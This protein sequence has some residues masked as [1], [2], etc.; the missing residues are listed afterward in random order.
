M[1]MT[2]PSAPS[3]STT[4]L[5]IEEPSADD[6]KPRKAPLR[7]D[8]PEPPAAVRTDL[9]EHISF[10]RRSRLQVFAQAA[11]EVTRRGGRQASQGLRAGGVALARVPHVA[12]TGIQAGAG[13][14]GGGVRV[15]AVGMH[16]GVR[17]TGRSIV[18][19]SGPRVRA[20]H[21]RGALALTLV[22]VIVLGIVGLAFSA[23]SEYAAF[24]GLADGAL[25]AFRRLPTDLGLGGS[26]LPHQ[27]IT[28]AQQQRA[29]ADLDLAIQ[30][31]TAIRAR[32]GHPDRFVAFASQ[33]ESIAGLLQGA[34]TLS[35]MALD[36]AQ[37]AENLL[38]GGL[39]L[40]NALISSPLIGNSAQGAGMTLGQFQVLQ[41][42]WDQSM[43][44]LDDLVS[45][46]QTT[47]RASLLALLSAKQRAEIAPLLDQLPQF[48]MTTVPLISQFLPVAPAVLGIGQPANYLVVTMDTSEL[49]PAGGFQG[50]YSVFSLDGARPSGLSLRDIYLLDDAKPQDCGVNA[51]LVVPDLYSTW[52][53]YCPWGV[54]DANLSPDFP[55]SAQYSLDLLKTLK[56][57]VRY[58]DQGNVVQK[59]LQ[60]AGMIAIQPKVIEQIISVTGPIAIGAPYNDVVNATN[61]EE[62]IHYYQLTKEGRAIG[63]TAAPPD[64]I[65]SANKR[66]TALV[67]RALLA[68]LKTLSGTDMLHIAQMLGNDLP[69]KDL[70]IYFKDPEAENFLRS[71]QAT[72][73]IYQG[74]G[75]SLLLNVAN[76]GGNKASDYLRLALQ[77]TIQLDADGTAHHTLVVQYLWNPPNINDGTDQDA[78]YNILYNSNHVFFNGL[79]LL[80]YER[81]YFPSSVDVK[82]MVI[83][84]SAAPG[85]QSG[86]VDDS[87]REMTSDILDMQKQPVLAMYGADYRIVGDATAHPVT[88]DAP[89]TTLS[90]TVPHVFGPGQAYQLHLQHQSGLQES[91]QVTVM[92]P[93][94]AASSSPVTYAAALTA[95]ALVTAPTTGCP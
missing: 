10:D 75:D 64:Q 84:T 81:F 85:S 90:W 87:K 15:A 79:F 23:Y 1:G 74:P 41:S 36:G 61:L 17:A 86:F 26:H 7:A 63:D 22:G 34:D 55:T 65:S 52:W 33:N 47:P 38:D 5:F 77:D 93:V 71:R 40:L 72:S 66:F 68:K 28:L 44:L 91:V 35:A 43:S 37:I 62:R 95:D 54:R 94:C 83:T 25:N 53:P 6:G 59:D 20:R 18:W 29:R 13:A 2:S 42:G 88:W 56:G 80:Q 12:A 24:K 70:Q 78:V 4:S 92:P 82:Q 58:D 21:L 46:V 27:P 50:N 76:I 30:D 8:W 16:R 73:E 57:N 48:A 3:E 32:L 9:W 89:S 19:V 39:A 31:L 67:G 69:T 11:A 49:R 14:I 60:M 51:A 45:R